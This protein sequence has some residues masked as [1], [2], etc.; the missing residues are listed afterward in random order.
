MRRR[1]ATRTRRSRT[2]TSGSCDATVTLRIGWL[3]TGRGAGSRAL[4]RAAQE[5]IGSGELDAE[6]AV[7]FCNRDPGEAPATDELLTEARG[8]GVMVVTRSSVAFRRERS[9][10]RSQPGA[11][12]PAWRADYDRVVRAALAAHP[13]DIGVLAGYMLILGPEFVEQ[14]AL[15]NFHPAL[16][17]G[18]AGTWREV[19]RAL[20]RGREPESGVMVH[21][22]IAAVDAGPVASF[23][24][25][26]LRDGELE[27]LW[28]EVE[29]RIDG[30]SDGELERSALFGAIRERGQMHEGPLL[31]ATLRAFADGSLRLSGDHAIA[32]GP[33]EFPAGPW[34]PAE[35][36]TCP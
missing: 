24:R 21:L 26:T 8:D 32:G 35:K 23:C 12:L 29:P 16:P 7:L 33:L 11:P 6:I 31:V 22:A 34:I 3:T 25:Y 14:H 18:P 2:T 1:R 36:A 9:G 30:A 20:I 27:P 10:K 13:F 28:R 19:I 15:L 17:T 5:A 4:Y